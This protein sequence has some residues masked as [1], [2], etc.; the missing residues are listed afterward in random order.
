VDEVIEKIEERFGKMSMTRGDDHNFLGMNIKFRRGKVTIAMK[1]H[2]LRGI[3][4]FL[5]EIVK[6][7]ATP[8]RSY[9]FEVR[10]D[11][12]KLDEAHAD[13]FH[14]VVASLLFISRRCRLDIQTAVGFLTTRVS[15]PD[16]DDWVKLKRVLQYLRGTLDMTLTIGGTDISHMRSWVD[17]SYGIHADRKSHTGGCISFGWGALMTKCQKQKLNVK[18]ST[19]GE[20]VGVSDY[21]S[22]MI[23]ARMFIEAQGYPLKENIL[24]Q[25]NQSAIKIIKNGRR[26]SGQK[27][28]HMD[29][30]Y[31]WY[32]DRLESEKIRVEY[33]PTESMLADFFT[34]PL[35]GK[36]F[37]KLRAVV[38]GYEHIDTLYE[39]T[40]DAPAQERVGKDVSGE[41]FNSPDGITSDNGKG[42]KSN[43]SSGESDK[44]D[45]SVKSKVMSWADVVKKN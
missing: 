4:T 42:N 23:W 11:A 14:S 27:T 20:I 34:K 9:L 2:I 25:D 36:L 38:M 15:E 35:Q 28:R 8:A 6:S 1:K 41:D 22:N 13:N 30:R 21:L 26:S 16:V 18:S 45:T 44:V 39:S 5:D 12:E 33:C 31:M 37:R 32:K 24:F 29:I 43:T 17:V 3:D 19:E 10:E 40:E 7:A